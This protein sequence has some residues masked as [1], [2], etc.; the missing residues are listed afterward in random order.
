MVVE[1]T[2]PSVKP[3]AVTPHEQDQIEGSVVK[4]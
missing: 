1:R 4:S 3:E 2:A